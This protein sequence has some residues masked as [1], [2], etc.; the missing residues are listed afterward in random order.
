MPELRVRTAVSIQ[1]VQTLLYSFLP[2]SLTCERPVLKLRTNGSALSGGASGALLLTTAMA[3]FSFS[4]IMAKQLSDAFT[5][6][7]L[8]WTRYVGLC[9]LILPYAVARP[10]ILSTRRW[11]LHLLR[12][13]S[14]LASALLFLMAISSVSIAEAT[15][16][17]FAAPLFV[18]LLAWLVL[19]ERVTSLDWLTVTLGFVGVLVVARPGSSSFGWASLLPIGASLAW[20]VAVICTREL[21]TTERPTTLL[22]ASTVAGAVMLSILTPPANT[23]L[24][25]LHASRLGLMSLA[26]SAGQWLTIAAYRAAPAATLSPFSYSQMLWAAL[27]GFAVFSHIPDA[28]SIVG[29]AIII[30]SGGLGACIA[31]RDRG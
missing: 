30:F 10:D 25:G 17:A 28:I 20:S 5:P 22:L 4:D 27:L 21:S 31:Q 1:S 9:A 29:M 11:G 7:A 26:W 24:I 16:M 3:C 19:R 12:A 18:T 6:F 14:F 15:A 2:R 13:A 23:V 8:A